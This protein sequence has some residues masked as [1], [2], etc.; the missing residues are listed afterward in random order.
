[1]RPRDEK[2][3]D[4]LLRARGVQRVVAVLADKDQLG[5]RAA[6]SE[7][8]RVGEP[9]VGHHVGLLQPL[10]TLDRQQVGVARASADERD[11]TVWRWVHEAPQGV[12]SQPHRYLHVTFS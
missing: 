6:F 4:T 5:A 1:M 11:E 9:V 12:R 10:Q 8:H 2:R 7:Q 3:V